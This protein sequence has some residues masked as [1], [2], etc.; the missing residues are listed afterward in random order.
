M[1][2]HKTLLIAAAILSSS[3][4]LDARPSS[5]RSSSSGSSSR[6]SSSWSSSKSSSPSSSSSS[7]SFKPSTSSPSSSPRVASKAE[8]AKYESAQKSGKAFT[9]KEAALSDFKSKN[10]DKFPS[11]YNSEPTKRPDHIP[12]QYKDSQGNTYN[13]TYNQQAGGYGYMNGL[14]AFIMYDALSDMAMA[15]M[16]MNNNGYHVGPPVV[17]SSGF[18]FGAALGITFIVAIVIIAILAMIKS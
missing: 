11:K 12:N 15:S 14:G 4:C 8:V 1:K 7:S 2:L 13:V 16:L 9:S 18:S 5:S 10:A 3:I 6:S 17:A